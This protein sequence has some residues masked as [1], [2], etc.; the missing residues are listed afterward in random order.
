MLNP[1]TPVDAIAAVAPQVDL[2]LCMSVNPGW[3]GQ[4]FI[5]E[6]IDKLK[7]IRELLPE[8]AALEVD[9]GVDESTAPLVAAAGANLLVAGS[10][11]FGKPDPAAAFR[12]IAAAAAL[13]LRLVAAA[14]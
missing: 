5:P 10:A 9:G 3:G 6:S 12:A 13:N 7:R 8:G 1:G 2:A 14:A 11:I 4:P